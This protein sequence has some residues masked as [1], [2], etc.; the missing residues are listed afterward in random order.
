[1]TKRLS[2]W[3]P[4]E[5][6]MWVPSLQTNMLYQDFQSRVVPY[7]RRPEPYTLA[8]QGVHSYQVDASL[9]LGQNAWRLDG[10]LRAVATRLL[11]DHEVWLELSFDDEHASQNPFRVC[12]VRGVTRTATGSLIQKL[13]SPDELPDW[14]TGEDEWGAEIELDADRM[15]YV[16][17]PDTYSSEVLMQVVRDLSEIDFNITPDWVMDQWTSHRRDTPPFDV[18][19]ASR[20]QRLRI[21]Q[22]ALPIGWPAREIFRGSSGQMSEYYYC[23]RELRFLHFYSSM[24]TRAEEA[25]RRVLMLASE[26][27]EF[28]ASVTANGVCT[29]GEVQELIGQFEAGQLTFSVVSDIILQEAGGKQSGSRRVV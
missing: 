4:S 5:P 27:G 7:R 28:V 17:T 19:E 25:L 3:F 29:P 14:Y 12:E 11:T 6:R 20:T 21:A 18:G 24:R 2:H 1:M 9:G 13:P 26:H 8:T 23:W 16:P 10:F 15:V 22:A